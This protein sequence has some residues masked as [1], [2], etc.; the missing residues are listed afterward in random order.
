MSEKPLHARVAEA[1]GCKP[2][3]KLNLPSRTETIWTCECPD[4]IHGTLYDD[5]EEQWHSGIVARY[6]LEWSATGPLIERFGIALRENGVRCWSVWS[7]RT[8]TPVEEEVAEGETPLIAVCH[9]I[10]AL[11][12]AGK[13]DALLAAQVSGR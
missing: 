7:E 4:S 3:E 6:D 8:D 10:L 12:K 1:L 9:L 11:S 13:L 5:A 2:L